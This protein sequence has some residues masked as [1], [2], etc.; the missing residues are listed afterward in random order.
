MPGIDRPPELF[1]FFNGYRGAPISLD[2]VLG[3]LLGRRQDR[4]TADHSDTTDERIRRNERRLRE[5]VVESS[6]ERLPIEVCDFLEKLGVKLFAIRYILHQHV[7]TRN[8]ALVDERCRESGETA[9][10]RTKERR[11][12]GDDRGIHE[13]W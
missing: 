12:G 6:V 9:D 10:T 3:N 2:D 11:S 13:C 4:F 5:E 7:T 8:V 1:P